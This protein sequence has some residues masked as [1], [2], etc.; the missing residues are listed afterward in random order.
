MV[1]ERRFPLWT[2]AVGLGVLAIVLTEFRLHGSL[3]SEI[4]L[5]FPVGIF[6]ANMV[7]AAFGIWKGRR[8]AWIVYL[9]LSV[10]LMV[11]IGA[12][13][14]VSGLWTMAKFLF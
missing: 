14:P 6:L 10:A 8:I 4:W 1:S 2:L 7:L 3:D 11:L 13:T 9:V 5:N 12:A